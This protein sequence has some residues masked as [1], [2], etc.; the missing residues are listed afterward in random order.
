M[1]NVLLYE[2]VGSRICVFRIFGARCWMNGAICRHGD[3]VRGRLLCAISSDN[4]QIGFGAASGNL[5]LRLRLDKGRLLC[6]GDGFEFICHLLARPV[7][8]TYEVSQIQ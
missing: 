5:R 4:C 8:S 7:A 3:C 2:G 1:N 6:L